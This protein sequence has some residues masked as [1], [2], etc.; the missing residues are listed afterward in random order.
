MKGRDVWVR[1]VGTRDGLQSIQTQF[2][3]EDK[4][5]WI[6]REAN[7]GIPEIEVGSFV[8]PKL[9]PQMADTDDMLNLTGQCT[10]QP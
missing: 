8:P 4:L 7:A 10:F 3:T 2:S 5:A 9:L 1:E 6:S